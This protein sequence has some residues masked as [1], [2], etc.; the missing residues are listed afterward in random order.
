M[1]YRLNKTDGSFL[2]DLN[3]DSV[4]SISTLLTLVGKNVSYGEYINENF[5]KLLEHFSSTVKP[6]RP[7][8]GQ[9][10][11]SVSEEKLKVYTGKEF[12][13]PAG[14]IL[15][16]T[17][18]TGLMQGDI[19]IDNNEQ[20]LWFYDGNELTLAGPV[21]KK[22]QKLSGFK[23]ST[24]LDIES[25]PHTVTELWSAGVLI[26]IFS[27]DQEFTP[28]VAIDNFLGN[29]GPGFN[30]SLLP[31]LKFKTTFSKANYILDTRKVPRPVE[32]FMLTDQ[33]TGTVGTV[34]ITNTTPL[35]L[36]SD[37]KTRFSFNGSEL[38][39]IANAQTGTI[40]GTSLAG[41]YAALTIL[42]D[43]KLGINTELPLYE[44]DVNGST[45]VL[46]TLKT[47]S[48]TA[49]TGESLKI[50]A[51]N[52]LL[53]FNALYNT[54]LLAGISVNRGSLPQAV[55]RWNEQSNK[56]EINNDGITF[57]PILSK[58][59]IALAAQTA[60]YEDIIDAPAGGLSSWRLSTTGIYYHNNVGIGTTPD[61]STML[62]VAGETY[63]TSLINAANISTTGILDLNLGSFF[64][65]TITSSTEFTIINVPQITPLAV[66]MFTLTI[67]NGG[68]FPV[69]WFKG[70]R[71]PAG[72]TPVLATDGADTFTFY[73]IDAGVTWIARQVTTNS[74]ITLQPYITSNVGTIY[75]GETVNFVI[76]ASDFTV[77][78][79]IPYAITGVLANDIS[80]P[81]TG[82]LTV[83]ADL[84]MYLSITALTDAVIDGSRVMTLSIGLSAKSVIILDKNSIVITPN[85]LLISE[86]EVASFTVHYYGYPIG[87]NVP[88]VIQGITSADITS[89]SLSGSFVTNSS[90]Q[91]IITV[92][93]LAD[94]ITEGTEL[95]KLSVGN[96]SSFITLSDTSVAVPPPP[97]IGVWDY[98]LIEY[99]FISPGR[100]LDTRTRLID[101]P[102]GTY[103]GWGWGQ[104]ADITLGQWGQDNTGTGYE[105]FLIK[106]VDIA[107]AYPDL[108]E[109]L[110]D[111]RA[112]WYGTIGPDPVGL[113]V[114]LF[115]GGSMVPSG[116]TWTN[117]TAT[118]TQQHT[119]ISKV[120]SLY[121]QS[122]NDP[123][124]RIGVL[125]YN[126]VNG[127][128]YFDI[129]DT[130][131]YPFLG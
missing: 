55:L 22:S 113:I 127:G 60:L 107:A 63:S 6:D 56:W 32:S 44:L 61:S 125:H 99:Y 76:D 53:N 18:P 102:S 4:D 75:E 97:F 47:S 51:S 67:N 21:Y 92:T 14:A 117:P 27:G 64:E 73:S 100:D 122:G 41:K 45:F 82:N 119:Y 115:R 81:L 66:I 33:D 98:I 112:M 104:T 71:W 50:K 126:I 121:S 88:Y 94:L 57:E 118:D 70:I 26:G 116:F 8:T 19:W 3:Y 77:G 10:W 106:C 37:G 36:G 120:V 85:A 72:T 87:V 62:N 15:S 34:T 5:V 1:T 86:G 20:Q 103:N 114:T 105:A 38:Q 79:V 108:T 54:D 39:I 13:D 93:T 80:V 110:V 109:I 129:T 46:N 43:N 29:I 89:G 24:V 69:L 12:K 84:K 101:P 52:V 58:R 17:I 90:G 123:G 78:Y 7:I 35:I 74:K 48:L 65:R 2:T 28:L 11:Y 130:T 40:S 59:T 25:V 68:L 83:D 49:D 23:I 9:V 91:T 31:N 16:K 131:S 111:C 96:S 30:K 128:G 42:P 124:Q 95:I